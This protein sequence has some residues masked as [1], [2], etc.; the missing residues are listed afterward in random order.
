M[1]IKQSVN[2]RKELRMVGH[3]SIAEKKKAGSDDYLRSGTR[4]ALNIC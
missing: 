2:R 3:L 1:T 4:E